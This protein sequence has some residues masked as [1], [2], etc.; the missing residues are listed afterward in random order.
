MRSDSERSKNKGKLVA[1][2]AT[3]HVDSKGRREK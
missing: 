1:S 3:A 2:P